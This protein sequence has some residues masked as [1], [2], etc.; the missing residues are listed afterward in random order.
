MQKL[1]S[2]Q[3]AK[4]I[5]IFDRLRTA[6]EEKRSHL[7]NKSLPAAH[8]F[9]YIMFRVNPGFSGCEDL[10]TAVDNSLDNN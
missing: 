8:T 9:N 7:S 4:V 6:Q 10:T 3:N 2:K 5:C 1:S